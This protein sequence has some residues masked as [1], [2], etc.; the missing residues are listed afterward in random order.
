MNKN[1]VIPVGWAFAI[2]YDVN[3][4]YQS[5][6]IYLIHLAAFGRHPDNHVDGQQTRLKKLGW[7]DTDLAPA[8]PPGLAPVEV[9]DD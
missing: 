2:S 8:W 1:H 9:T 4:K 7:L 3:I 5:D 6:L